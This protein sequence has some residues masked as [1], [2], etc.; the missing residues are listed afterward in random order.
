MSLGTAYKI[1]DVEAASNVKSADDDEEQQDETI[2]DDGPT[3]YIEMTL[4]MH[5]LDLIII[6]SDW[7]HWMHR[8]LEFG[9][10]S[11]IPLK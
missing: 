6:Y 5:K 11:F 10:R 8:M 2:H 3:G 1:A 4:N 9:V 7:T